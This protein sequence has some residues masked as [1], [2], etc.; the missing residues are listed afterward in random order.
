MHIY[1]KAVVAMFL[2]LIVLLVHAILTQEN[3]EEDIFSKCNVE[4][5][6]NG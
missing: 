5:N 3:D 4:R 1:F 2:L 6:S